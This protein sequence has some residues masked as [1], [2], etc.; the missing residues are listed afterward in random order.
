MA[1]GQH[2]G[3]LKFQSLG[4]PTP[5]VVQRGIACC[6]EHLQQIRK[7][8]VVNSSRG[9]RFPSTQRF[10]VVSELDLGTDVRVGWMAERVCSALVKG[11][12]L[13]FIARGRRRG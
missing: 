3:L 4:R 8:S 2:C 12:E 6:V 7:N 13:L 5:Q 11:R 10:Q 9:S 1:T